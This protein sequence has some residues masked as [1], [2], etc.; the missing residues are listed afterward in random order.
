MGFFDFL[1][2]KKKNDEPVPEK[3]ADAPA[4]LDDVDL[5]GVEPPET[6]YTQ[7]YQDFLAEQEAARRETAPI[8]A[9]GAAREA[10]T[11]S[12]WTEYAGEAEAPS[13]WAE[14]AADADGADE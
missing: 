13:G 5:S 8:A 9:E 10:E 1:K 12:G 4:S 3:G 14:S 7:E 2:K 6:R 11:P